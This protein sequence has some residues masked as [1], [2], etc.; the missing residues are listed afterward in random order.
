MRNFWIVPFYLQNKL[1]SNKNSQKLRINVN[2]VNIQSMAN[3]RRSRRAANQRSSQAN[4][5]IIYQQS[6]MNS[7]EFDNYCR[8]S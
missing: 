4:N 1:S 5:I 6:E 7:T 3:N 8:Q 2:Q